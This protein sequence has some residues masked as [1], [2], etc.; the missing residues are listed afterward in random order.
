MTPRPRSPHALS[1]ALAALLAA[2]ALAGCTA[3]TGTGAKHHDADVD[4]GPVL[5][6]N[7]TVGNQTYRYSTDQ[8]GGAGDNGSSPS[9]SVSG[10]VT[11]GGNSTV[12]GNATSG[13]SSA[14][15]NGTAGNGSATATGTYGNA[16]AGNGGLG[17]P[18]DGMP[19]GPAPL[20]VR[21]ELGAARLPAD[22]PAD[23]TFSWGDA[24]ATAGGN[25]S[26]NATA[27]PGAAPQ[28]AREQ[29]STL[30]ATLTHTFVSAGHYQVA[31]GLKVAKGATDKAADKVG[32]K[33]GE[34]DSGVKTLRA[35]VHVTGAKP[36]GPAPG[37]FLGNQTEQFTGSTL[38]SV[39]PVCGVLDS[40]KWKLNETYAGSPSAVQRILVNASSDGTGEVTLTLRAANGTALAS[41]EAIDEQG[42]FPPAL[43]TIEVEACPAADLSYEVT[44]VGQ[45]FAK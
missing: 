14:Q 3:G 16:S 39:P 15:G 5:Y 26:A 27:S 1:A 34:A 29:G 42:D 36:S 12:Q 10:S 45:H 19:G 28:R 38:A 44:A 22:L 4:Q 21:V 6:L 2:L 9:G 17:V 24:A 32:E 31:F 35:A 30:P 41:G 18:G 33:A 23:W 20:D 7:V 37:S 11:P 8:L 40:F 13:P 25:A 43:Y